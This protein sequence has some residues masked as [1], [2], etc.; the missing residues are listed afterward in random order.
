MNQ[1]TVSHICLLLLFSEM[2][3]AEAGDVQIMNSDKGGDMTAT[4]PL[5]LRISQRLKLL[6]KSRSSQLPCKRHPSVKVDPSLDFVATSL[7]FVATRV[8]LLGFFFSV[9][10]IHS[11]CMK[12]LFVD[13]QFPCLMVTT[14][15]IGTF[16]SSHLEL[17]FLLLNPFGRSL[18]CL[19][20]QRSKQVLAGCWLQWVRTIF[21]FRNFVMQLKW[22]S[23]I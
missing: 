3:R 5:P 22:R 23:S 14:I 16:C 12:I 9:H 10:W 7:D 17:H 6:T 15:S 8:S 19:H 4:T 11:F 13:G 20:V 2:D 1:P 21:V 18:Y